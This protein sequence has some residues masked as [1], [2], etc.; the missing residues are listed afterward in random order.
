MSDVSAESVFRGKTQAMLRAEG[1]SERAVS[2]FRLAFVTCI[3]AGSTTALLLQKITISAWLVQSGAS[4]AMLLYSLLVLSRAPERAVGDFGIY[5][6]AFTDVSIVTG[7]LWSFIWSGVPLTYVHS[8]LFGLYF[9]VLAFT[10]MHHRIRLSVFAGVVC[11]VE[12]TVLVL[13]HTDFFADNSR[14]YAYGVSMLLLFFVSALSG[15]ISHNNFR[16]VERISDSEMRYQ[17]LVHRLPQMLF[18]L[19]EDQRITW[20]NMSCYAILGLPAKAVVGHSVR[21]FF[22]DK[23]ALRLDI[24]GARGT[25]ELVDF[26]GNQRFV[27]LIIQPAEDSDGKR[28]WQGSMVDV[29]EREQAISQRE[30]MASRLYQ[31]QKMESLGT[32][33]GG[34]AHDFNN[35]LQT[36]NELIDLITRE[37]HEQETKRRVEL[38]AET[39]MDAKILVSELFALG[40]KRPLNYDPV[41]ISAFL[42]EIVPQFAKQLGG[43][44]EVS[45]ELSDDQV[46]AQGDAVYLKR[47]FQ[48]LFGNSRDAMAQGG[49]ISVQCYTKRR[50]DSDEGSVIIRVSDSGG[51]IPEEIAGKI[52]DPFFTTK[53]KGKGTGLGLALV[54]R[55]VS[56]HSGKISVEK[57]DEQGTTFRIEIPEIVPDG[58]GVDTKAI[59]LNRIKTDVL[60]MDD[61][62]KIRDILKFFLNDFG[63]GVFEASNTDEAVELLSAHS[64]CR[65]VVMDWNLGGENPHKA[66]ERMR[67]M[68]PALS[69]IVVSGYPPNQESIEE[70]KI[71]KWLTKPYDKNRLDLEVQR[72]L[73]LS[74]HRIEQTSL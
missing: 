69:F 35:I 67:E 54:T 40:R 12:Y 22:V 63:Y 7:I 2:W 34:M 20:A 71:S 45:L 41:N 62:K 39:L 23:S 70:M 55:I 21:S 24:P 50:P 61:D 53:R 8:G 14:L 29:T 25:F 49:K 19:D 32:L 36:V 65:V 52:F 56:L 37:T 43:K 3:L 17:Q 13:F 10:A 73:F 58:E 64:D 47:I 66:I 46:W 42:R 72:V 51:G 6:L 18:T 11:V 74:E 38:I 9:V 28:H 5:L 4:G 57:S 30:E 59:L 44:Y 31:Y 15:L 33:A 1:E 26:G 16:S 68:V 27:D 60:V 48:N